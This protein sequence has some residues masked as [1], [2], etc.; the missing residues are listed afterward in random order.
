M[1]NGKKIHKMPDD[2]MGCT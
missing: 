1:E 2:L